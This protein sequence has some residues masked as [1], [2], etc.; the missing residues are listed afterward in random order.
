M[1]ILLLI[2]CTALSS[3]LFSQ[4]NKSMNKDTLSDWCIT[5]SPSALVN[6]FSGL[7]FGVEKRLSPRWLT[8]LEIAYIFP[9]DISSNVEELSKEGYRVKLG[10]KRQRYKNLHFLWNFYFRRTQHNYRST[11]NRFGGLFRQIIDYSGTKTLIGPTFGC[12]WDLPFGKRFRVELG[13]STGF[14][15]YIRSQEDLPIDTDEFFFGGGDWFSF[16]NSGE[17]LY[18]ILA[19]HAKFKMK[20]N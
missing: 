19:L 20:V 2:I 9:Q 10:F 11:F 12:A 4:R 8:E 17:D 15:I 18:P 1:R 5:F 6:E 16:S 14:G 3:A 7:Q 13:A